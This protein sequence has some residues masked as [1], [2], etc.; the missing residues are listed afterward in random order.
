[1]FK[2]LNLKWRYLLAEAVKS[3]HIK[4]VQIFT[5]DKGNLTG[6]LFVVVK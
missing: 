1:M 4:Q 5:N 3:G 2:D 6:V